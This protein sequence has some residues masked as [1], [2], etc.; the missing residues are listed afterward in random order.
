[1]KTSCLLIYSILSAIF[2]AGCHSML[3]D[4]FLKLSA[5]P[6]LNAV[7]Q[8]DSQINVHLSFSVGLNETTPEFIENAV[9]E[10][11]STEGWTEK[12]MYVSDG[13]YKSKHKSKINETY[14]CMAL[15]DGYPTLSAST[16]VQPF[17]DIE[18][19]TFTPTAN[20]D[21]DG[22]DISSIR[23]SIINHPSKRL[24]WEVRMLKEGL[25]YDWDSKREIIKIQEVSIYMS[26]GNDPVLQNEALPLTVFSN[27]QM[28]ENSYDIL[29]YIPGW[30]IGHFTNGELTINESDN[31]YI[32]LRSVDE[33]YYRFQ[34]QVYLY[35]ISGG[36]G[37]STATHSYPLYSNVENGLGI[38]TS[39]SMVRKRIELKK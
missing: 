7:L 10:I 9:V 30:S 12:L 6:V 28:R 17:T 33:S 4:S 26:A 31:F 35:K 39:F 15:I 23:F 2:L 14:S 16:T 22:R 1:M 25:V 34:K 24:F 36:T 19:I 27:K 3:E 20:K 13:W 38:L 37:F 29:F 32:E 5:T 18:N 11:Q 21:E 8:P